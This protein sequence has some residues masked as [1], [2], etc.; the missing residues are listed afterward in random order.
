M[1][2]ARW[3]SKSV[4]WLSP[5]LFSICCSSFSPARC[6]FHWRWTSW[7]L[8]RA[9][10]SR[11]TESIAS[12]SIS[13]TLSIWI[14]WSIASASIIIISSLLLILIVYWHQRSRNSLLTNRLLCLCWLLRLWLRLSLD[15][16]DWFYN[17]FFRFFSLLRLFYCLCHS[18][19]WLLFFLFDWLHHF[20]LCNIFANKWFDRSIL[21]LFLTKNFYQSWSWLTWQ[22]RCFHL[23]RH[24]IW[25]EWLCG[26]NESPRHRLNWLLDRSSGLLFLWFTKSWC[27]DWLCS[28]LCVLRLR[29]AG[30]LH[31]FRNY[32]LR[33]RLWCSSW[34][35]FSVW[36]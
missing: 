19:L 11:D 23:R 10:L 28:C 12:W 26:W 14:S 30:W 16:L 27:K 2:L 31:R 3:C 9:I 18:R 24:F 35:I 32:W 21:R 34:L 36:A 29:L 13:T 4:K 7:I 5:M 25:C 1:H 17:S 6:L 20:W 15:F 8:R 22:R 33:K